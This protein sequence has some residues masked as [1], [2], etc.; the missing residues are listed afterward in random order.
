M[1]I[2]RNFKNQSAFY[3][4]IYYHVSRI[5]IKQFEIIVHYSKKLKNKR[6]VKIDKKTTKLFQLF[7][8]LLKVDFLGLKTLLIE[9]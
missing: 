6:V 8:M 4:H 5:N 1:T 2:F 9:S 7:W 3:N